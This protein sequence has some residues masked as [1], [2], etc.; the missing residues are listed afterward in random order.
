MATAEACEQAL[1]AIAE[2]LAA[3]PAATRARH[4]LDRSVSVHVTD[5]ALTWSARLR[6][7]HL[8]EITRGA[9]GR[10]QIALTMTSDDLIALSRGGLGIGQTMASGR[11]RIDAS[12]LDLLRLHAML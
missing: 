3:V 2:R 12:P 11:L 5:L 6:D 10:G 7:G 8:V 1:D 4:A 9:P